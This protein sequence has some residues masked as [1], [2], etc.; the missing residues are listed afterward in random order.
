MTGHVSLNYLILRDF[1]CPW[2]A[3]LQEIYKCFLKYIYIVII[4]QFYI[5][6]LYSRLVIS[7]TF[8]NCIFSYK[9]QN[10]FSG[11]KISKATNSVTHR[12]Q[13][14]DGIEE[15][16]TGEG[17]HLDLLLKGQLFSGPAS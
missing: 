9:F 7:I 4:T 5:F 10:M 12:S 2:Q 1:Q 3:N 6:S 14:S 11:T 16:H 15:S 13:A 17:S 8:V